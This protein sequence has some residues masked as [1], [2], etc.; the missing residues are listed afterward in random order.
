MSLPAFDWQTFL[1]RHGVAYRATK[2]DLYFQCPFC[3]QAD[4]G[5]KMGVSVRGRGWG[6]W[7]VQA[8]RGKDPTRLIAALLRCSW[9][10]A[11][12]IAGRGGG[13]HLAGLGGFMVALET[14]LGASPPAATAK[15]VRLPDQARRLAPRGEGRLFCDYLV[16]RG[17]SPAQIEWLTEEYKLHYCMGGDWSYRMLI[18]VHNENGDLATW[19]GRAITDTAKLRYKT[20]TADPE[21][22]GDGPLATGPITDYLLGLPHLFEG[23]DALVVAEGPFDAMRLS[24]FAHEQDMQATCLFGKAVS[25]AQVDLLLKLSP[26]YNRIVLLLDPDA[27]L[28]IMAMQTRLAPLGVLSHLLQGDDDPGE[29]SAAVI[30]DLLACLPVTPKRHTTA[31]PPPIRGRQQPRGS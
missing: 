7:R 31:A 14:A 18:P 15:A 16:G 23:G 19:T 2:S 13:S 9:G 8:H 24:L 3:G 10:E 26:L 4:Q 27:A 30:R 6:C 29:M 25:P 21:K 22:A 5:M 20:L 28:D 12:R 11:L 1:D 17:F